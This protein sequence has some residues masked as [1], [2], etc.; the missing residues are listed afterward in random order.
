M[1]SINTS[2]STKLAALLAGAALFGLVSQS[3]MALGTAAGTIISNQASLAYTV[4]GVAQTAAP[5][6]TTTFKVGNKVDM[7]VAKNDAAMVTV[8]SGAAAQTGNTAFTVVNVG[9]N[10]QDFGLTPAALASATANPFG[11]PATS[12]FAVTACS[13]TAIT[14]T[15]TGTA[16][17]ATV[18]TFPAYITGLTAGSSAV[19]TVQCS[20]PANT[21][22][23]A[24]AV[25]QLTATASQAL[26]AGALAST[27]GVAD[28][29][30]VQTVVVPASS[31]R[32]ATDAYTVSASSLTI[33]KNQAVICDPINGSTNP[34]YI[35]GA[36][37]QYA[38]TISNAAAATS[39]NLQTLTDTLQATALAFDPTLV[40]GAT[41]TAA[42]CVA[43]SAKTLSASGFA[44][45]YG[46]G[47]GLT[48]GVAPVLTN[49]TSQVTAAG[50]SAAGNAVTIT[51]SSLVN[52]AGSA[53]LGAFAGSS[54]SLPAGQ[55]ITVYFN[56]IVQ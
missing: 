3:A 14:V 41:L 31:L 33:T 34:K 1:K 18:G 8:T 40:G 19:V 16:S 6:N 20:V 26:G 28:S 22:N 39:A 49:N 11:T 45:V 37:V 23:A 29:T 50:A 12:T 56:A 27:A 46:A 32:S 7:T 54:G 55:Y 52:A 42:E 35:P 9:N 2:I 17:I 15:G 13:V 10:T 53:T 51:Y 4:G 38:V 25:D 36:Y 44:A 5:S 24:V 43:A 30:L 47:T 21:A 48:A